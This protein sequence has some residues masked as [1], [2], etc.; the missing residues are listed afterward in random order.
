MRSFSANQALVI[1]VRFLI[2][3]AIAIFQGSASNQ[4]P[5]TQTLPNRSRRIFSAFISSCSLAA[6]AASFFLHRSNTI[7]PERLGADLPAP[8]AISQESLCLHFP[9]AQRIPALPS[10]S[11]FARPQYRPG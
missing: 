6:P 9:L 10:G 2:T 8:F 11:V 1:T 7:L 5:T 4:L 3:T